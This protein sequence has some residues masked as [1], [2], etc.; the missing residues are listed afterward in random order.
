MR[1]GLFTGSFDPFTIGHASIVERSLL[2]FDSVVI[3]IGYNERKNGMFSVAQR[4]ER[5]VCYYKDEPRVSVLSYTDL[6]IDLAKRIGATAIVKGVRTIKDFEYER[7]QADINKQIGGIDTVFLFA[8]PQYEA[9]S[10]S[11]VRELI[12]FNHDVSK[13]MI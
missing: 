8:E 7:Q 4:E 9:I 1:I 6:T 2:L 10:S 11:L 12:N 3:A 5:I 13:Y